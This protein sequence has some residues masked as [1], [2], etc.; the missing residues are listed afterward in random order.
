MFDKVCEMAMM[1]IV[2]KIPLTFIFNIPLLQ[3]QPHFEV[4]LFIFAK[5]TDPLWR[6]YQEQHPETS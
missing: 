3:G 5:A 1:I 6:L 4:V 2:S